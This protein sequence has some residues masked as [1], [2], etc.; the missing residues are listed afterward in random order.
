MDRSSRRDYQD[1]LTSSRLRGLE[2]QHFSYQIDPYDFQTLLSNCCWVCEGWVEV[3][4]EYP[5]SSLR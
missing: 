4:F 5:E 3:T 1:K 2:M